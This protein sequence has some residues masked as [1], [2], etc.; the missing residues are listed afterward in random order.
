MNSMPRKARPRASISQA[1]AS[2]AGQSSFHLNS[3]IIRGGKIRE[4]SRSRRW[5]KRQW[6]Q[7]AIIAVSPH[8]LPGLGI[9]I[10]G[11]TRAV[12]MYLKKNPDY[13]ASGLGPIKR[14]TVTRALEE[15]HEANR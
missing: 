3:F 13:R 10:S 4:G 2:F 15:M 6:V 9:N 12:N 11:L 7:H 14:M 1:V 8:R 5:G